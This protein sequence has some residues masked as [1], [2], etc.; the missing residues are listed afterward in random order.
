[1]DKNNYI[2][3]YISLKATESKVEEELAKLKFK[4]DGITIKPEHFNY[5]YFKVFADSDGATLQVDD[6]RRLGEWLIKVT[7]NIKEVHNVIG[8]IIV[9]DGKF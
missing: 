3:E 7:E 6:A 8:D 9:S 4:V 2:N 1:M 5:F